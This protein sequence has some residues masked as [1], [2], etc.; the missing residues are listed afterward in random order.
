[1]MGVYALTESSFTLMSIVGDQCSGIVEES[2]TAQFHRRCITGI[3]CLDSPQWSISCLTAGAESVAA[4]A[5]QGAFTGHSC[6][7]PGLMAD[8][9]SWLLYQEL[10][11]SSERAAVFHC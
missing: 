1:M 4:C 9:G 3:E 8:I 10:V 11:I 2:T 5:C 7:A 6:A